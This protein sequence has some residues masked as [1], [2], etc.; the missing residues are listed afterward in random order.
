MK[1]KTLSG[2]KAS[3]AA[4][5]ALVDPVVEQQLKQFEEALQQF[6]QQKY[7]K[8]KS[9]FEKVLTG[10]NKEFAD[11]ARTHLRIAEQRLQATEAPTPRSPEE[12]Y[13]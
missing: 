12:H 13:Q 5:R 3:A 8:S 7:S 6:Q 10:P 11:R 1:K 4:L 2:S 9:L